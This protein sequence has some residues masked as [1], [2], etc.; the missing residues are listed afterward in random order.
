MAINAK[1]QLKN[2]RQRTYLAKD[3]DSFRSD[4]LA[5]ARLYFPDKIQDFTEAS[6]GGLLL[7]MASFVGD[8]MSFYLDHQFNEL[9]W[10][11]AIES[12]NIRKHL[13]N[14]GVKVRGAA[15]AV[16]T[17][18]FYFEIPAGSVAGEVVPEP[19]LLPTVQA[20][21][22]IASKDGVSFS[23]TED[24]DFGEKDTDEQYLYTAVG[25]EQ[26]DDGSF[27]SFVVS[28]DGICLSGT[29]KEERISIPNTHKAFRQIT[30]P[31]ENITEIV[32]V[33]DSSGNE[34]Y[35]VDSLSQD[36]VFAAII[37]PTE[38]ADDVP[39]AIEVIPAPYRFMAEYEYTT[40]LTKLR[41]GGGDAQTL[42][43]DII[44]DPSDLA[45]PLYGKKVFGRFA[46]DPNAMLQTQTL[47]IAPRNTKLTIIYRF[48]GGLKHNVAAGTVR[49]V[50]TLYLTFP[51]SANAA[52]SQTVRASVDVSNISPAAGGDRAP[53]IDELRAQIP[54]SRAAQNRIVTKAD[55]ISRVY[56]LPNKFGRVFRVGIRP[57]PNNSL[58]SQ[59]YIVGRNRKK[60]LALCSDTLKK[61]LRKYLNEFRAVSDAYDILDARIVNFGITFEV[62]AHPSANKTQV[63]QTCIRNLRKILKTE[64]FQIDMPIAYADIQNTIL[65]TEGVISMI[66][67]TIFN[68]V[69]TSQE[70]EYSDVSF[71][72]DSNTFQQMVVGPG[73]SIFELKYPTADIIASVR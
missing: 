69:G 32:S 20:M 13:R 55:L 49:T 19:T 38:D 16:A 45:L 44:P 18:T 30:L 27:T 25:V 9:N 60:K 6:L 72:V 39:A 15:P 26:D 48:G 59:I 42:D 51:P 73:G 54:S 24:L 37:N 4:L 64:N 62:A 47:G 68:L 31:D 36:T 3:F 12:R 5:H 40:K 56:T 57:N 1:K 35:E 23:L 65:N 61:N 52:D 70:R 34:Y 58:A 17:V 8:S 46:I 11:T 63:A 29:R 10:N 28:R 71:N 7:D 41:F 50:N 66:D 33:K 43:N 67:L 14:A 53:T 22:A 2:V 21:T